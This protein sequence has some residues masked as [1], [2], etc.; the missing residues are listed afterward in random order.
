MSAQKDIGYSVNRFFNSMNGVN[1]H[2]RAM[3]IAAVYSRWSV[4][5]MFLYWHGKL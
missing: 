1:M 4:P 3:P 5:D 2:V